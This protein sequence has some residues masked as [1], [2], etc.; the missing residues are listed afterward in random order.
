MVY[1]AAVNSW[2]GEPKGKF[3]LLSEIQAMPDSQI[4][5]SHRDILIP[6]VLA[7]V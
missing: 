3:Y 2:T 4:I 1:R 7:E 5:P 6:M